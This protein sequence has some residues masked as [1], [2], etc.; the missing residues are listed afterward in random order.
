MTAI[1]ALGATATLVAAAFACCTYERWTA[2]HRPHELAWTQALVMF[3]L[4]SAA[5]WSAGAIG[6]HDW[7]FRAFYLFGAIVNV[8]YL[9]VGTVYLLAGE[10]IGASVHR[11]LHLAAAFCA[12]AIVFA[13]MS[14]LPSSGLPQGKEVFGVG[15]R[16]MAA[17]GSGVGAT[18]LI[19]GALWSVWTLVRSRRRPAAGAAP[20]VAPGRLAVTNVLIA[21]GSFVLGLGGV[22]YTGNDAE[23]AFGVFLVVGITLLFTGF[24]VSSPAPRAVA[25]VPPAASDDPF[26]AELWSIAHEPRSKSA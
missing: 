18:V 3:T 16:I 14:P 1:G 11:W 4:A 25:A 7:N 12:G 5:Y 26:M 19:A 17:V 6:W 13:P 9:A 21:V 15:P 22:F 23:L 8:P 20:T 24:L 2:R 10:R